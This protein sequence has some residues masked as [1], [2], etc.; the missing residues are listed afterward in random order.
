MSAEPGTV[1]VTLTQN[2]NY[3]YIYIMYC[4]IF[5]DMICNL[6]FL[7]IEIIIINALSSRRWRKR[8]SAS[9][10]TAPRGCAAWSQ[11]RLRLRTRWSHRSLNHP[12]PPSRPINLL[13]M[14][15]YTPNL[16]SLVNKTPLNIQAFGSASRGESMLAISFMTFGTWIFFNPAL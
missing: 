9:A 15:V 5:C 7:W 16:A 13:T 1:H 11:L 6:Y 12:A 10:R 8:C 14:C 3:I 4:H 2:E